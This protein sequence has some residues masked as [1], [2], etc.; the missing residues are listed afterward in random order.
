M[1]NS[2]RKMEQALY[3]FINKKI[4]TDS[5]AVKLLRIFE[6]MD[7]QGDGELP[8]NTVINKF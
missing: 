4:S 7:Q 1:F 5:S 2:E 8:I 3:S 6:E